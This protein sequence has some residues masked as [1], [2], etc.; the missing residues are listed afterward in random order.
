MVI[1]WAE[2]IRQAV[3]EGSLLARI[4][5]DEGAV[6]SPTGALALHASLEVFAAKLNKRFFRR[7]ELRDVKCVFGVAEMAGGSSLDPAVEKAA[8]AMCE[9]DIA[10]AARA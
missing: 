8:A 7:V 5:P 10:L 3:P 2:G 4:A 6:L 9:N 1:D